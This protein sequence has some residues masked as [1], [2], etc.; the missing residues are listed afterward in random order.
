M[1]CKKLCELCATLA[2]PE[3]MFYANR[4]LRANC[5]ELSSQFTNSIR[6]DAQ[7]KRIP[8]LRCAAFPHFHSADYYYGLY[9][10]YKTG[11]SSPSQQ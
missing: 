3:E 5:G 7:A 1:L 9:P 10:S 11:Y 4:G 6:A 2:K 8:A